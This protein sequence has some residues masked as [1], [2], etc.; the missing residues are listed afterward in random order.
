VT[1]ARPILLALLALV[2]ACERKSPRVD[3]A[4]ATDAVA[5]PA[6]AAAPAKV[7]VPEVRIRPD[8]ETTVRVAWITPSGTTIN[9]EA[10]FRIR[11]TRSEGLA[12][13]PGDV[14]ATGSTVKVG[15]NVKVKPLPGAPNATVTGA[16]DVVVC[17]AV[18]HSI[19]LPVHRDV[20]LGFVVVK[21]AGTE[22]TVSIPLPAAR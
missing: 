4:V 17:D 3:A 11:W 22:A 1:V 15:F 9:D 13:A 16:I 7:E 2:G 10:P 6:P 18:N 5:Q 20:E 12:E 8:A 19:C 21:D 14:K